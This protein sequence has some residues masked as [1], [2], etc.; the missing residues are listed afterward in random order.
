M[1]EDDPTMTYACDQGKHR[2]CYYA[3]GY[4]GPQDECRCQC[5]AND[6]D[7]R[8]QRCGGDPYSCPCTTGWSPERGMLW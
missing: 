8:C 1:I 4:G 6:R 3:G 7:S 2:E 5:H